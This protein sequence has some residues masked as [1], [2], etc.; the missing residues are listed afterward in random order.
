MKMPSARRPWVAAAL[1]DPSR[2]LEQARRAARDGADLLEVRVDAFPKI[3]LN[4]EVLSSMLGAVR[5]GVRRPLLLT[6]RLKAE[7][8]FWPWKDKD[9]LAFYRG[10]L[11]VVD[12]VDVEGASP[13]AGAVVRAAR[14]AGR[15]SVL[16][17]HDFKRTPADAALRRIA[18]RFARSGADVLKVA[19]MPRTAADVDRLMGFCGKSEGRRAFIAMGA[20]G[21][22][23]RLNPAK[24]GSCLT[25]GFVGKSAAPGQVPVRV[26]AKKLR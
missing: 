23:T 20:L 8:G 13:L 10:L 1:T 24:W 19:A 12:A 17:H 7:G 15:W 9:R 26:L 2:L 14:K 21:R 25:Y 11:P 5:R 3:L 22:R 4:V 16:S 6:L 18:D